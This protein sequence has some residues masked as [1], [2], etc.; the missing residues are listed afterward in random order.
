MSDAKRM[1]PP[2]PLQLPAPPKTD[3]A[4]EFEIFSMD[5][6]GDPVP[7]PPATPPPRGNVVPI[8]RGFER[9]KYPRTQIRLRVLIQVDSIVFRTFTRDVS[10]GGLALEDPV[11]SFFQSQNCTV[12][13]SHPPSTETFR[14]TARVL[15]QREQA[16]FLNFYRSPAESVARLQDWLTRSVADQK[17]G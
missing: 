16:C 5:D 17:A 7:A 10:L 3:E 15:G 14:F 11:P 6:L 2:R 12:L 9:R 13:L 1:G 8:G 4:P